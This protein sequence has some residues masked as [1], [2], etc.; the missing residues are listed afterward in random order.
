[1]LCR[2]IPKIREGRP[3]SILKKRV[4]RSNYALRVG[5]AKIA[6]IW[7]PEQDMVNSATS[8]V[9]GSDS[10]F[11]VYQAYVITDVSK[12]WAPSDADRERSMQNRPI[13]MRCLRIGQPANMKSFLFYRIRFGSLR[14]WRGLS[15]GAA[16]ASRS[17]PFRARPLI[18]RLSNSRIS[19]RYMGDSF[20]SGFR[21]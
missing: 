2:A 1:M 6:S 17:G 5:L 18:S 8:E 7:R 12:K 10:A 19:Q 21:T 15:E 4:P 20:V 14:I 13:E 3:R 16:E 11:P 9:S